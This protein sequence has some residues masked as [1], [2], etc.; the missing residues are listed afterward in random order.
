MHS[1]VAWLTLSQVLRAQDSKF[2]E[3][4]RSHRVKKALTRQE[5]GKVLST[6]NVRDLNLERAAFRHLK[7]LLLISTSRH[8]LVSKA[9][10][11]EL[12]T[13]P[14]EKLGEYLRFAVMRR[15]N[16][17]NHIVLCVQ[18]LVRDRCYV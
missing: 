8:I 6:G 16:T 3:L 13:S 4:I 10:L 15:F 5:E 7:E 9:E 14:H 12:V 17:L 11:A 1:H 2:A 18:L